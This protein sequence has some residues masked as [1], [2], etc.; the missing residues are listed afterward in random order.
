MKT[1]YN[2]HQGIHRIQ[3]KNHKCL[4]CTE[5]F[6]RRERLNKHFSQ[7]HGLSH[8]DINIITEHGPDSEK[9]QKLIEEIKQNVSY[10]KEEVYVEEV[11][12][13]DVGAE[14]VDNDS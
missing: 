5:A 7:V 9:T 14:Y 3:S 6:N 13:D 8:E 12:V 10:V 1:H 2:T 11:Y 4:L